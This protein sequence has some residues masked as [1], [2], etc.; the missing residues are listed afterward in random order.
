MGPIIGWSAGTLTPLAIPDVASRGAHM[1]AI[2][3]VGGV[4]VV[5]RG[6]LKIND[7]TANAT[8]S[9]IIDRI[10]DMPITPEVLQVLVTGLDMETDAVVIDDEKD[11]PV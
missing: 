2:G 11:G 9:L 10:W 5:R 6:I 1:V 8:C 7:R 3:A 4:E